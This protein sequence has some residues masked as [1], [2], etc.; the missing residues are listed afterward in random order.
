MRT[1]PDNSLRLVFGNETGFGFFDF[2]FDVRDSFTVYS[3]IPQLRKKAIIK[4]LRKDF[5]LIL[6]R[7][8]NAERRFL[9]LDSGR[10]YYGYP[11][12]KG[13]NYYVTDSSCG[14]LIKMQRASARKPVLE[15]VMK[16]DGQNS[17]DS[18]LIR[19]LNFAFQISLKK[20][21]QRE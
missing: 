20:I 9:L 11:Q 21:D 18:I 16:M 14:R 2:G 4:T 15:A 6:F 12:T 19:H 10:R 17:P 3:I 1:M 8:M 5:E 7:K 13:I